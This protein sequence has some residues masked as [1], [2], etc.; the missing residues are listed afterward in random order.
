M[1]KSFK[2]LLWSLFAS[3]G[4]LAA[5]FL[6]VVIF[7]TGLAIPLGVLSDDAFAYE[8]ML[9]FVQNPIAKL[10]LFAFVFLLL[11]HAA[12]RLRMAL[13]DLGI[14]NG[15][16]NALTCYGTAMLGTIAAGYIL[17]VI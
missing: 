5:F 3:G 2:P 15:R 8:R 14:R 12:H 17:V 11:W 13:H 4:M 6:P 16:A 7:I 1:A 10:F 9:A